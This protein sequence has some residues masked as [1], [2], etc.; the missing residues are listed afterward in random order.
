ML[1]SRVIK[2]LR[3]IVSRFVN[4]VA[5]IVIGATALALGAFFVAAHILLPHVH[6]ITPDP[7]ISGYIGAYAGII[8]LLVVPLILVVKTAINRFFS[9]K[10]T[11]RFKKAI[12]GVWIVCITIFILTAIF[13]A[14]TFKHHAAYTQNVYQ[15]TI[16][17]SEEYHIDILK[18]SQSDSKLT[19]GSSYISMSELYLLDGVKLL[20]KPT[21]QDDKVIVNVEGVIG[22]RQ[23]GIW[24]S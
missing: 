10:S 1:I 6:F 18:R 14:S 12:F 22:A 20:L 7:V 5:L 2:A 16:D 8:G 11:L 13:T 23:K 15:A 24:M 4:V 17:P 21:D 19:F 9:F 3:F